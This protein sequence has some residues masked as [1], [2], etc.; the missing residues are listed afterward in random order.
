[1]LSMNQSSSVSSHGVSS[2]DST[3]SAPSAPS[4]KVYRKASLHPSQDG[5]TNPYS[6]LPRGLLEYDITRDDRTSISDAPPPR[7]WTNK[8]GK[9][10]GKAK[11]FNARKGKSGK[12]QEWIEAYGTVAIFGN[13]NK[14]AL[15][16]IEDFYENRNPYPVQPTRALTSV[17]RSLDN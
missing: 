1:M 10:K 6:P 5:E 7:Q 4:A 11:G 9:E 13:E 16:N 15:F 3:Y 2:Y 17:A 8:G 12:M 14:I